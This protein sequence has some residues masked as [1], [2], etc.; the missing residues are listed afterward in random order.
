MKRAVMLIILVAATVGCASIEIASGAAPEPEIVTSDVDRFYALYDGVRGA[1]DAAALQ[2]YIDGGSPGLQTLAE[3]R[4]VS[5]ERIA[6]AI[7]ARPELYKKARECAQ[8][9][10]AAKQRLKG[11]LEKLFDLY[12]EAR[13]PAVTIAVGRGRPVGIGYPDT[14]VQISL[15]ALC[16]ADF[17]NPDVEDRFVYVIAHEYIH[18]QQSPELSMSVDGESPTVLDVSLS[19]GIAEFVG[20]LISGDVAY[21]S[22]RGNTAGQELE[23]ETAFLA[24]KDS[25]DLSDWVYN[26][27]SEKPGDL[28]YWVG[29]R[30]A[31]AHYQNARDKSQ[32]VTDMLEMTDPSAFLAASGW[33]PGISFDD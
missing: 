18:V 19:E 5:G 6:Q 28:G 26:A 17:L 21:G 15:E 32:A 4:D 13:A 12:P 25:T 30:I 14:G 22:L 16:A 2:A 11:A 27:S 29:Y 23:I 7:K 24:N 31:K 9:L 20:E 8:A 1:P 3:K 33:E 10:P